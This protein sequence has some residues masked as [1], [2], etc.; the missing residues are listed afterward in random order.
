MQECFADLCHTPSLSLGNT[1]KL[2]LELGGD[3]EGQS[4]FFRHAVMLAL[5]PLHVVDKKA[6][7]CHPCDDYG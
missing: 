5:S 1:L 7:L 3:S 6:S 2:P 4:G